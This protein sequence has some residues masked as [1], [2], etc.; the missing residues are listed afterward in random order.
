MGQISFKIDEELDSKF[1][2]AVFEKKGMKRG[3]MLESLQEAIELWI[4]E[5]N[6]SLN[7]EVEVTSV[8]KENA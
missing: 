7:K 6:A 4:T 3:V 8:T 5:K 1:R 2:R